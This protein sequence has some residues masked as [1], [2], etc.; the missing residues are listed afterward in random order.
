MLLI[1]QSVW[2]IFLRKKVKFSD[3]S[4]LNVNIFYFLYSTM[5]VNS[6]SLGCGQNKTFVDVMLGFWKHRSTFFTIFFV[7]LCSH[8]LLSFFTPDQLAS[9]FWAQAHTC[10]HKTQNINCL[11]LCCLRTLG[12]THP[13]PVTGLFPLLGTRVWPAI[14]SCPVQPR[15]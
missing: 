8:I 13:G 1:N 4:L 9:L 5:P 12:M 3:V 10:S 7:F 15:Q 6:V 11:T 14:S 2:V